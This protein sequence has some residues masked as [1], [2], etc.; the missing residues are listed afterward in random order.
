MKANNSMHKPS[1]SLEQHNDIF[2]YIHNISKKW[3]SGLLDTFFGVTF[4]L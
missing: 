2:I 3:I 4:N 1:E